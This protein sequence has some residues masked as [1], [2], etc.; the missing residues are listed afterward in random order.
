MGAPPS[1]VG[2]VKLTMALFSHGFTSV[3]V[4]ALAGSAG[5]GVT[6]ALASLAADVPAAFV[7]VTV[8]VYGVLFVSPVMVHSRAG[9]VIVH[10]SPPGLAVTV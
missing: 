6:G 4:G 3:T 1:S 7:A 5:T 9:A 10:V 8:K 2:A